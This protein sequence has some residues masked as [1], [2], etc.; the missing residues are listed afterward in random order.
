MRSIKLCVVIIELYVKNIVLK[1][2]MYEVISFTTLLARRLSLLLWKKAEPP[3]HNRWV[4][5][6]MYYIQCTRFK[7]Q[8]FWKVVTS[9]K[10]FWWFSIFWGRGHWNTW[11][12]VDLQFIHSLY[13][14]TRCSSDNSPPSPFLCSSSS[15]SRS[16]TFYFIAFHISYNSGKLDSLKQV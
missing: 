16:V 1:E 9:P 15:S 13:S 4:K 8:I 14:S 3:T 11:T 6:V 10:V 7:K 2:G 12:D 5:E